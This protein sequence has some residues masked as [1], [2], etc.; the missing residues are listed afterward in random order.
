MSSPWYINL[1]GYAGDDW[2]HYYAVEP[3]SFKVHHSSS[4][5]TFTSTQSQCPAPLVA[6]AVILQCLLINCTMRS[7]IDSVCAN[8]ITLWHS[9]TRLCAVCLL[10]RR[11]A[12]CL[13]TGNE[14]LWFRA[15]CSTPP[16][17]ASL[18][19]ACMSRDACGLVNS[20]TV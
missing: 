6:I 2:A 8:L 14:G 10:R 1:G 9:C 5:V 19:R 7:L 15:A 17:M 13:V 4:T 12:V 11:E 3:L 16:D 18:Q 20:C